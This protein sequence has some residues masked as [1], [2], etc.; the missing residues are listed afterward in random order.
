M[1]FSNLTAQTFLGLF[2]YQEPCNQIDWGQSWTCLGMDNKNQGKK[3][4]QFV[5]TMDTRHLGGKKT[6][7]IPVKQL[8]FQVLEFEMSCKLI[9][10]EYFGS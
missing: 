8:H 7:S 10:Q 2:M 1:F 5:T 4:N 6:T 9:G 3:L